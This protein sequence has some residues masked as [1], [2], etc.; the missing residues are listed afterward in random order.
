MATRQEASA[1]LLEATR[2]ALMSDFAI[3]GMNSLAGYAVGSLGTH[4]LNAINPYGDADPNTGG[5]LGMLFSPSFI[6][7]EML[8]RVFTPRGSVV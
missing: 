6:K 8:E 7:R 3:Q 2:N 5:M 4:A 1:K